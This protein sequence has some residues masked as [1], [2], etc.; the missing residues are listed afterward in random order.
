[1][2]SATT[3]V[4]RIDNQFVYN[5][6]YQLSAR[7]S[8]VILFLVSKIDPVRQKNLIEQTVSVRELEQVLKGDAKKWGGLYEE[9]ELLRDRLVRK[10]IYLPTEVEINGRML[11]GYIN[12][13][14]HI[15]P[16]KD[17]SGNAAIQFLFS[18]SLQPFLLN[19]REYV[20]INFLEVIPLKS[21]FSIRMFQVFRAH[22]D[23]MG[24]YQNRSTL[25]Y[26]LEDFKGL[27]GVEGKYDDYRN[28]RK[29][30]LEVI[31]K[32][33]NEHTSIEIT[34][35]PLKKGRSVAAIMF[36]F[37]DKSP[38]AKKVKQKGLFDG[39]KLKDLSYS[40][41][42]AFDKL[43][44][45]G[46]TDGVALEMI[47]KVKGSEFICFE[48]WYFDEVV[49]IFE[50]KTNQEAEGAKAGTL[51]VWFLKMKVFEQ[52]DHFAGIM[53]RIQN[54][55]KQLQEK[56]PT[57]WDNRMLSK[58]ITATEFQQLFKNGKRK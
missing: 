28:L 45:Y 16:M 10:G 9:L 25:R 20:A 39:L 56:T 48:D 14:Q 2:T 29:K 13:F 5:A 11:S 36:E 27:L 51:V 34:Y 1:M 6:R 31:I 21:T 23:R 18:Q 54:R 46:I 55:K 58:D 19:L 57:K 49:Q 30:V 26:D 43:V 24:K 15:M 42:L 8:K 50:R 38:R 41:T 32:E 40:Q 12:W 7:E 47:S 52:G 33:I 3:H 44:A 35:K 22:R 53:E 37:W 4:A 17:E